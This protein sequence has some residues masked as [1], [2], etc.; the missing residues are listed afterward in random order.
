MRHVMMTRQNLQDNASLQIDGQSDDN[1]H[2][3]ELLMSSNAA[4]RIEMGCGINDVV[5]TTLMAN[6]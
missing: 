4:V 2:D 1:D 6:A 3:C 5:L